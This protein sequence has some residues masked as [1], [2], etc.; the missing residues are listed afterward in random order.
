MI[1]VEKICFVTS[2][3]SGGGA[4]RVISI[5]ANKLCEEKN[6]EIAIVA[7]DDKPVTYKINSEIKLFSLK[8]ERDF[9]KIIELRN[10]LKEYDIII[11]FDYSICIRTY[12]STI[13]LRKKHIM[14]ERNDPRFNVNKSFVNFARKFCY[15]RA[16]IVV[17]QTEKAKAYFSKKI[18]N[19][20][21]VIPNPVDISK[22]PE[23]TVYGKN[24]NRLIAIG[25]LEPQKNFE[26]LIKVFERFV[27][28]YPNYRLDIFG[29]GSEHDKLQRL[30]ETSKN[31]SRIKLKGFVSNIYNE[32]ATSTIYVSSSNFEGI[33]NAM[34]EAL[35]MGLPTIV[36]DCNNGGVYSFIENYVN[37]II[38]K[39]NDED[40]L[41]EALCFLA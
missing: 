11:S 12:L 13:G 17:F 37:G 3:L 10:R 31:S 2:C 28:K 29:S 7:Y 27:K 4:E 34:L 33:S 22:I 20:G 26:L 18:Q 41:Y 5:L 36:T 24:A 14:S 25:R 9:E 38:V 8:K 19:K 39:P 21:V 23:Q 32:M 30:I 1:K 15:T 40:A 6:F 35:C 16:N